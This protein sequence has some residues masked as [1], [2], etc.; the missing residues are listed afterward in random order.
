MAETPVHKR[1]VSLLKKTAKAHHQDFINTDGTDPEWPSWYAD[2]MHAQL[3]R[4]LKAGFTRSEL[5]YLIVLADKEHAMMAP[6]CDWANYYTDFFL[7]RY[8]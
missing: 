7:E 1:L 4:M 3:G 5:I 2:H 8:A 6:G